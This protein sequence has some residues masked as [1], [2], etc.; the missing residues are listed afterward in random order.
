MNILLKLDTSPPDSNNK[1]PLYVR[2]RGENSEGK[3]R[4]SLISTGLY[5]KS[6]HIKSGSL[7]TGINYHSARWLSDDR[8]IQKKLSQSF[9]TRITN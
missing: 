4:E 9:S 5:L 1:F 7:K 8:S 3:R 2:I 6:H